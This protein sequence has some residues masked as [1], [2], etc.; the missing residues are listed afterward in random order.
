[1][2]LIILK[3]IAEFLQEKTRSINPFFEHFPDDFKATRTHQHNLTN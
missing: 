2:F 1:M 3:S